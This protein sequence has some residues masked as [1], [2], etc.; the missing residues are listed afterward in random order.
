MEFPLVSSGWRSVPHRASVPA[1]QWDRNGDVGRGTFREVGRVASAGAALHI[2]HPGM[3][4][5][6]KA[7]PG[8]AHLPSQRTGNGRGIRSSSPALTVRPRHNRKSQ[9]KKSEGWKVEDLRQPERQKRKN[10]PH[11]VLLN[12]SKTSKTP[13]DG[14]NMIGPGSGTISPNSG[15]VGGSISLW[16]WA[17]RSFS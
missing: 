9:S 15:L 10:F 12:Q 16:A 3:K 8:G 5:R 13:C 11:R 1:L 7:G 6:W 14:L 17:L 4:M 2:V